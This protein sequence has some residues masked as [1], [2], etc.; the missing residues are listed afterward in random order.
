MPSPWS[1]DERWQERLRSDERRL[2]QLLDGNDREVVDG[3]VEAADGDG[4][5][6]FAVVYG[7]V[8]RGERRD[9]SDLDIY[10]EAGDIPEPFNPPRSRSPL[11]RL[12][13]A[14]GRTARQPAPRAAVRLRLIESALI[15][16]DRGPFRELLVAVDVEG[17]VPLEDD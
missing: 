10:F 5:L 2:V 6:D 3:T 14:I 11:A 9:E 13:S 17:L 8:A 15:V 12:R 4:G 16:V 7:S 1:D